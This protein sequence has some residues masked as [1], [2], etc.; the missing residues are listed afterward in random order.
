MSVRFEALLY[1]G[2]VTLEGFTRQVKL[3][4]YAAFNLGGVENIEAYT[5]FEFYA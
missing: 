4:V 5:G 1:V 3:Y 2:V